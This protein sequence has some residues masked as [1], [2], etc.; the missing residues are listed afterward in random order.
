MYEYEILYFDGNEV[1]ADRGLVS[2][3]NNMYEATQKLLTYYGED[4]V[5]ELHLK[6]VS[7]EPHVFVY[8]KNVSSL[9][10]HFDIV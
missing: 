7:E 6:F 1:E 3:V 4:E 10:E 5:Q 8:K 9:I 2:G